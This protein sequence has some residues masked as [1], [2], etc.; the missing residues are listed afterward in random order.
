METQVTGD[1]DGE[2]D[3]LRAALIFLENWA[4]EI[5]EALEIVPAD[6][7]EIRNA[8]AVLGRITQKNPA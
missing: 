1:V 3:E 6:I 2:T 7:E 8:N 4:E 5:C